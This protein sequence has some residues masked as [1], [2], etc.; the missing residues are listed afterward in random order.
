MPE[1]LPITI[2][3]GTILEPSMVNA[4]FDIY[5]ENIFEL[6]EDYT[7]ISVGSVDAS[8]S[9]APL[10]TARTSPD[11]GILQETAVKENLETEMTTVREYQ[12]DTQSSD[13]KRQDSQAGSGS[14]DTSLRVHVKLLDSLMTLAGELV[15]GRNQLLQAIALKDIHSVDASGQRL[16]L[17]TSELQEAI[18]ATRCS[19]LGIF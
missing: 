8:G 2:L 17:I 10:K 16:N 6:R 19:L 9:G 13:T 14:A 7:L 18:M 5:E 12:A 1:R 4:L 11:T 3:Y 15:L